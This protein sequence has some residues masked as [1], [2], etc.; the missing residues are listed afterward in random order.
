MM[1]VKFAVLPE[2]LISPVSE[3]CA[4]I[5]ICISDEAKT[6]VTVSGGD[7]LR[8]DGTADDIRI[9]YSRRCELFRALSYLS[10]FA[11]NG[12][13]ICEKGR[14]PL[15]SYMADCSRNAVPNAPFA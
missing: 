1:K 11:E 14:Y 7:C 9:T 10:D 12:E 6:T 3:Y 2:E 5:G 15:L 13:P 8:V 4:D